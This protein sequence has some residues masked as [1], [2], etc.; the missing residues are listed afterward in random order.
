M[1]EISATFRM[2]VVG[3]AILAIGPWSNTASSQDNKRNQGVHF[4]NGIR[5]GWADQTSIVIWTRSTKIANSN[6]KDGKK[7]VKPTGDQFRKAQRSKDP[8]FQLSIQLPEKDTRL[9]EMLGACPGIEST[10]HLEYFD[11]TTPDKV[12]KTKS[13]SAKANHDFAVQWK[14]ENLKPDTTYIIKAIA[15]R[16]GNQS[17]TTGKIKT[18]PSAKKAKQITFCMTTCHDFPRRDAGERGHKIYAAMTKLQ[19]DFTVHA[20]DIEYYDK[21]FPYAWSIEL[22]RFKWNRFFALPDNRKFYQSHTTYFMKDDHDTLKNDC[23]P[24]QRYGSVTFE[25]GKK[26]FNQ[27]QFPSNNLPYKTIRWGRDLQ[28][29]FVEGRDYRSPNNQKDGPDKTIWGKKQKQWFFDTVK[30][31]D[32]TYKLL[33]SPTPILGPDRTNKNDNHS[34]RGFKTEGN[35]LRQF[36]GQQKN[37]LVFCGDRHWQYASRF[38][39]KDSKSEVWEFGCGPGSEKHQLGWKKGDKRPEHRFLRVAGGF[40]S[41]ELTQTD[42]K[43]KL[44]IRHHQVDGPVVSTIEFETN[45]PTKDQK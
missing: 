23:W 37:L 17:S 14:L 31:S 27:E 33:F 19:P 25:Q 21:P 10:I 29:W 18:A 6:L 35:E 41:G 34:N 7:F 30:K 26:L 16:D 15:N 39:P 44:A 8:K 45:V 42:K 12:F 1:Y 38:A 32:A 11:A 3:M 22:M 4:G 2:F 28:I 43:I 9:D 40:L 36:I 5:N 20:G 24:G 13:K